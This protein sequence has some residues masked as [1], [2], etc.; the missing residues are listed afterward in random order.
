[1]P[2]YC[3]SNNDFSLLPDAVQYGAVLTTPDLFVIDDDWL[4]ITLDQR[5]LYLVGSYD[6]RNGGSEV[7][8]IGSIEPGTPIH[9]PYTA[10]PMGTPT[11]LIDSSKYQ[12]TNWTTYNRVPEGG[13]TA[14]LLGLAMLGV[15]VVR[16]RVRG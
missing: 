14:S 2:E 1:M 12:A 7:W 13:T 4:V 5:W 15:G 10:E 11:N 9:I 6:G 16:R 3:R 8:Y